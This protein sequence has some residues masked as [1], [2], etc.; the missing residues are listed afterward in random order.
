[1]DPIKENYMLENGRNDESVILIY[2]YI[3]LM[4]SNFTLRT[5]KNLRDITIDVYVFNLQA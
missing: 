3:W 4:T 1:M 5:Q 2:I